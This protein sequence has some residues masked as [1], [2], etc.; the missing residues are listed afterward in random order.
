MRFKRKWDEKEQLRDLKEQYYQ[1]VNVALK[2]SGSL[3]CSLR[4]FLKE[5]NPEFDSFLK[6]VTTLT[7]VMENVFSQMHS[8]NDMLTALEFAYLF[9]PTICE[10][11]KQLTDSGF[12][13]YTFPHSYYEV[14]DELKLPFETCHPCLFHHQ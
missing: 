1:K 11:L 13:Y 5:V 7:L 9:A 6:L 10:S 12:V 2:F 4:D 8:G 3:C 14:P